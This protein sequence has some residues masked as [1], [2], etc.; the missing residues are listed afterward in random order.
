M[1]KKIAYM[2]I[3]MILIGLLVSGCMPKEAAKTEQVFEGGKATMTE[4]HE[5]WV[6]ALSGSWFEMGRQYGA[7]AKEPL[8][9]FFTEIT[10]DIESKG[11]SREE[12]RLRAQDLASGLSPELTTAIASI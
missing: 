12:Q 7:L 1:N 8:N 6:L 3:A 9:Q 2:S 11:L 10:A 4:D 5:Y